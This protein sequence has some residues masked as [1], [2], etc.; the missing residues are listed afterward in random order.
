LT[1]PIFSSWTPERNGV[2]D[3]QNELPA[4]DADGL[5]GLQSLVPSTYDAVTLH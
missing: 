3:A 2:A 4:N 5:S 1:V